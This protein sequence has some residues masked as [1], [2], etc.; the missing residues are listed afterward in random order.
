MRAALVA[1]IIVVAL[2][3]SRSDGWATFNCVETP[4]GARRC[5]CIGAD[6]CREMQNSSSC[7]SGP[8]CDKSELG[9][10]FAAA[11]R[12]GLQLWVL[13]ER[14]DRLRLKT[15]RGPVLIY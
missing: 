14:S 3:L 6:N 8:E 2:F 15:M 7:K 9:A 4:E 11:R 1:L 12:C 10:I 13:S 5:A